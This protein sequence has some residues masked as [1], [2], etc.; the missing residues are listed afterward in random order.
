VQSS[1]ACNVNLSTTAA[2]GIGLGWSTDTTSTG[3]SFTGVGFLHS[4]NS[5]VGAAPL[6]LP[7]AVSGGFTIAVPGSVTLYL[8]G[9]NNGGNATE[10]CFGT[11]ILM[12]A[13]SQ[14]Q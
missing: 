6:E 2:G 5:P 9:F 12:F 3:T 7:Y 11:N 10:N 1:G 14:L 4:A 13:T 8:N